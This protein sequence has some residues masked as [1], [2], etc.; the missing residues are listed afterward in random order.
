MEQNNETS[1]HQSSLVKKGWKEMY[2]KNNENYKKMMQ[3][4][5]GEFTQY[6][7]WQMLIQQHELG[8]NTLK[9]QKTHDGKFICC[10]DKLTSI[11]YQ[12]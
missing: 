6:E 3:G 4:S 8:I 9:I 12:Q 10:V 7:V 2:I 11:E 5:F 1:R